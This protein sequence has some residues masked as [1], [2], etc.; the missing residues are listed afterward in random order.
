MAYSCPTT[1]GNSCFRVAVEI[2]P[3]GSFIAGVSGI[4]LPSAGDEDPVKTAATF[5]IIERFSMKTPVYS[6]AIAADQ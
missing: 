3:S 1:N 6:G 2:F 4:S 5:L